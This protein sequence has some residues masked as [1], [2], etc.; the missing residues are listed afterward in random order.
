MKPQCSKIPRSTYEFKGYMAD[1]LHGVTEQWLT[2]AP[3]AL[4]AG[5]VDANAQVLG[6]DVVD[7]VALADTGIDEI[8]G[9]ILTELAQAVPSGTP[10]VRDAI[11]LMYMG[12]RNQLDITS[13]F[14][15]I[16]N[17]ADV[18]ITKKPLSD[19]AGEYREQKMVA[20]P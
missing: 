18:V 17:N 1:Y 3:S 2:V 14:K 10:T 4:I 7:A 20:G 15:E 8:W 13:G 9:E 12:L 6:T 5:R 11:M 19:A 16:H